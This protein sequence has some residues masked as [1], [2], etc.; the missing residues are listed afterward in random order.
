MSDTADYDLAVL[1]A[2]MAGLTAASVAAEA[3]ARVVV[4]ERAPDV[5]G[6]ALVSGGY[7]WTLRSLEALAQASPAADPALRSAMFR[8]FPLAVDLMRARGAIVKG[9]VPV[10]TYGR[11]YQLD[12]A[13]YLNGCIRR[14]EAYGGAVVRSADV[15]GT[16][17]DAAGVHGLRLRDEDGEIEVPAG[18]TLLA[19][20]GFHADPD[21]RRRYVGDE[22]GR[23]GLRSSAFSNGAGLRLA[24][25]AGGG[26]TAGNHGFYGHLV[27][28]DLSLDDLGW[29]RNISLYHSEHSLLL[30]PSGRRVTDESLGD[31][32]TNQALFTAGA[33]AILVW[34]EYVQ[35]EVVLHPYPP[36]S[37]GEDR[38]ALVRDKGGWTATADTIDGL[39]S[40]VEPWGF[41][42]GGVRATIADYNASVASA[43]ERLT[44]TRMWNDRPMAEPPFYAVRCRPSITFAHGGIRIDADAHVVDAGGSPIPGLYVA[45]V[46]AGDVMR[47]GYSGGL[48][49]SATLALMACA[50]M[51]WQAW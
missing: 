40:Q 47:D 17:H 20:G 18:A 38:F 31:E 33:D 23:L 13:G 16:M 2:G 43:P 1:G 14:I 11:G 24:L 34:D 6:N 36:G 46:D 44:P 30:G 27:P 10:M 25:A 32:V 35:R 48:A 21:L 4:F 49:Q 26:F 7:L 8:A 9:P 50:S 19:T 45:G 12:M 29:L 39:A 28:T 42:A 15:I 22:A 37:P 5:G 51:G 41:D 3:G